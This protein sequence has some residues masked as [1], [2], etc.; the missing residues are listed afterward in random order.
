M[1][2]E[3]NEMFLTKTPHK[4][5]LEIIMS[6]PE[7]IENIIDRLGIKNTEY[8]IFMVNNIEVDGKYLVKND[9]KLEMVSNS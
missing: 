5:P 6:S 4:S 1:I 3:I 9:D 8:A 7:S 2:I